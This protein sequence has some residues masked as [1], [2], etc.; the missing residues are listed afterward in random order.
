MGGTGFA[1]L[2]P[3]L[4]SLPLEVDAEAIE[5]SIE[6]Q[7][8]NHVRTHR[9]ATGHQTVFDRHL[10]QLLHVALANLESQ[11]VGSYQDLPPTFED[12]VKMVCGR[13]QVLKA[14][15]VQFNHL[16]I[17]MYWPTLSDR[18]NVREALSQLAGPPAF[19]VRARLVP[20]P[21][22]AI[23]VWVMLAVRYDS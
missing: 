14:I 10:S 8:E 1:D 3:R 20:Y 9:E 23:A 6:Q 17:S 4:T 5:E 7:I 19:V 15:P 2:K 21:E 22:G 16:K 11:R 18:Q 12:M 13:D